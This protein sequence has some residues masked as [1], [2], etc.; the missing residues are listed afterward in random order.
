MISVTERNADS[1]VTVSP[2]CRLVFFKHTLENHLKF[3]LSVVWKK[4]DDTL[5]YG[6]QKTLRIVLS[7]YLNRILICSSFSDLEWMSRLP[8]RFLDVENIWRKNIIF[9]KF[10]VE[11]IFFQFRISSE[12]SIFRD[13]VQFFSGIFSS[14]PFFFCRVLCNLEVACWLVL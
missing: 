5:L 3:C 1:V 11:I 14:L 2:V 10:L 13:R 12:T 8:S 9:P 4:A 7:V 6:C